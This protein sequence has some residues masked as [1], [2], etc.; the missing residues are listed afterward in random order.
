MDFRSELVGSFSTGSNDNPTVEIIEAAFRHHKMNY[1][2]INCEVLPKDLKAAVDGAR[3]M[4][5][6]GFNCSI[7]HKVE[8]IKH[9][10]GLGE[11]ASVIGAVNC[12]V[13]RDGK[14]IGENTDGKGFLASL[15]TAIDPQDKEVVIFGAGGAARAVAVEVAL[16]GACCITIVN[17]DE[18]RGQELVAL[19][20]EKTKT[21]TEF[22]QW[23]QTYQIPATTHVVVNA[24]SMGMHPNVT[25]KLDFNVDTL[26]SHMVVADVVV[27]PPQTVLIKYA[28]A[29][30]CKVLNGFGMI[31]NQGVLSVKYW[32][33][34]DVSPD[35]MRERLLE[36]L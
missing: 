5:W 18:K 29:K 26:L 35:V 30:G 27:N 20:N 10:D 34:K 3:A 11:S 25:Q 31:V 28:T 2:Y 36:L 8:V 15:Q 24:T 13:L 33:G 9:L 12:A 22:V 23:S 32:T 16:A 17:R 7:P 6:V 4:G 21:K 14:F 19:L 1:R